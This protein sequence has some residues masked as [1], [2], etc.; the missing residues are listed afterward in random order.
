MVYEIGILGRVKIDAHSLNNEG[1][2]GNV[3][4]P[5]TVVLSDGSK[6]DGISG[7]MLK[8]IHVEAVWQLA[9]EKELELCSPC[10]K[11]NPMKADGNAKVKK[12]A[13]ASK[14]LNEAL[15]CTICDIHGFLV[16]EL[17]LSRKSTVEFGWALALPEQFHRD[18]HVHSRVAPGEKKRRAKEGE[19]EG[20]VQMLY[21][22]PTRSGVY[23]FVS[24]FQPWRL[25]LNEI[26]YSYAIDE[27]VRKS[28]YRL[29][30]DAYKAMMLRLEGA[31]TTTRLPHL[32]VCE[33]VIVR[34]DNAMPVPVLSPLTQDYVSQLES[35]AKR[36]ECK[37]EK[38]SNLDELLQKLDNLKREEVYKLKGAQ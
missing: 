20:T 15:K 17:A 36:V 19:E 16:Q 28:R 9:R 13:E 31:M 6:T 29:A 2:I 33:G 38:F 27:N 25:G 3:T 5:R 26:D 8:H 21:N 1:A 35:I 11:L 37:V 14:A 10:Q 30:L 4:E 24:V 7:E 18:I 34:S 22:R 12:Q 32:G 23:A